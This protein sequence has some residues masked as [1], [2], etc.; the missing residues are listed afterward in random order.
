MVQDL[1]I[2]TPIG[3]LRLGDVATYSSQNNINSISR[4]EGNIVISVEAGVARG[5]VADD[6]EPIV[7][8]F[9]ESYVFPE[10]VSYTLA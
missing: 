3:P 8:D 5:L 2:N 6:V 4:K 7:K 10:G 1:I 9:A